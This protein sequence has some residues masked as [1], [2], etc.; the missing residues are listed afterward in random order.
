MIVVDASSVVEMLFG[1]PAASS[2]NRIVFN[3]DEQICAPHLIDLEVTHVLRRF[4]REGDVAPERCRIALDDF[5]D[6]SIIRYPQSIFLPRI[7]QLRNNLS[8]YDAAYVALAEA[9]DA[10]LV[11]R[12]RRLANAKGHNARIALI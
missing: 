6:L 4:A 8:A 10:L 9:L 7:W 12:D 3:S 2:I 11:T 5:V 1:T